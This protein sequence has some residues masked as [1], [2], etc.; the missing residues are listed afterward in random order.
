MFTGS[1]DMCLVRELDILLLE[2]DRELLIDSCSDRM[3]IESTEYLSIL[4]LQCECDPLSIEVLLDLEGL[5][6]ADT[7]LIAC[8]FFVGF[9]FLHALGC[10]LLR[11]ALWD[12]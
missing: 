6:E 12:Q 9:D 2:L 8:S 1:L 7:S 4:P 3:F 5:S 10:D 11:D